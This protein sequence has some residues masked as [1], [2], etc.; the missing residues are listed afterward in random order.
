MN[1]SITGCKTQVSEK[2]K[3]G[4]CTRHR[5]RKNQGSLE[6]TCRY[7]GSECKREICDNPACKKQGR[8]E[9]ERRADKKR[10]SR[11]ATRAQQ[12]ATKADR[13]TRGVTHLPVNQGRSTPP[14]AVPPLGKDPRRF[15]A[16][17][18]VKPINPGVLR[19]V[20]AAYAQADEIERAAMRERNR[21]IQFE[22]VRYA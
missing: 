4:L 21:D 14:A 1:C 3:T 9:I 11:S 22:D 18:T 19:V 8:N 16:S 12:K 20:L 10:A 2:S 15:R 17:E 13:D 6:H 5:K 7:C